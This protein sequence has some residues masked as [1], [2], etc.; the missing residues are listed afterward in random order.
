MKRNVHIHDM[1]LCLFYKQNRFLQGISLKAFWSLFTQPVMHPTNSLNR[2]LPYQNIPTN[3]STALVFCIFSPIIPTKSTKKKFW[4]KKIIHH[5][6]RKLPFLPQSW[7]YPP[8]RSRTLTPTM[9]E[10]AKAAQ[11]VLGVLFFCNDFLLM[12]SVSLERLGVVVFFLG[13]FGF[14]VYVSSEIVVVRVFD[15]CWWEKRS[16]GMYWV[17]LD[18]KHLVSWRNSSL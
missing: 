11:Q 5:L 12:F 15:E 17:L 4:S 16:I 7:S 14:G 6:F 9:A 18:F 8:G 1:F 3:S 13:S 10:T 2:F